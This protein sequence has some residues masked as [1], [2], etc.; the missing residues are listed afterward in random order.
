MDRLH[1][2][3][4]AALFPQNRYSFFSHKDQV[5][6]FSD[7]EV[8]LYTCTQPSHGFPQ[9]R[10]SPYVVKTFA[11]RLAVKRRVLTGFHRENLLPCPPHHRL[12]DLAIYF[13]GVFSPFEMSTF[14]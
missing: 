5:F 9:W 13:V 11:I 14:R 4:A 2:H 6:R 10:L 1:D 8:S 7:L 12:G 3:S